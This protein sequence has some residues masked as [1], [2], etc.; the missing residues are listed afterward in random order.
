MWSVQGL[1]LENHRCSGEVLVMTMREY[2]ERRSEEAQ[3]RLRLR[4]EAADKCGVLIAPNEPSIHENLWSH[5]STPAHFAL[6]YPEW[7]QAQ[8]GISPGADFE[9]DAI[10]QYPW[11]YLQACLGFAGYATM[12]QA[13]ATPAEVAKALRTLRPLAGL[14][15]TLSCL[16]SLPPQ[17]LA[18]D[19]IHEAALVA[20]GNAD[21]ILV[22]L[23]EATWDGGY[24]VSAVRDE[25]LPELTTLAMEADVFELGVFDL[26]A[27]SAIL[28]SNRG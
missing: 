28:G 24:V 4:F 20:G 26:R 8:W 13:T 7:Y 21:H 22:Q 11:S 12:V 25:N 9:W 23:R 18:A 6:K 16:E 27:G 19:A 10:D 1:L 17:A 14:G 3:Q 5:W 15:G 2:Y